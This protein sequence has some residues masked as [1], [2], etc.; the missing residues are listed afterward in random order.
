[1]RTKG[2]ETLFEE[3]EYRKYFYMQI[4]SEVE[5]SISYLIKKRE[6]DPYRGLLDRT[7]YRAFSAYMDHDVP[8]FEP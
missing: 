1:M 3:E 8:S 5:H 6:E 2:N 4:K 7:L